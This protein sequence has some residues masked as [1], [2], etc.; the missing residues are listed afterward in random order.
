MDRAYSAPAGD[1]ALPGDPLTFWSVFFQLAAGVVLLFRRSEPRRSVRILAVMLLLN[2]CVTAMW[3]WAFWPPRED[4]RR[5]AAAFDAPTEILVFAF[6]ASLG[7][8][9]RARRMTNVL[10]VAAAAVGLIAPFMY[11]F[12]TR[13]YGVAFEQFR[14]VV[15]FVG[16]G[17]VTLRLSRGTESWENWAALG[18]LARAFYWTTVSGAGAV[19]VLEGI[20]LPK[21]AY[22]IALA[23]ILLVFCAVALGRLLRA[24]TPASHTVVVLVSLS[25]VAIGV[26]ELLV[27]ATEPVDTT[28]VPML[29][30]LTLTVH[31]PFFL[32]VGL[33]PGMLRSVT[34]RSLAAAVVGWAGSMGL[35]SFYPDASGAAVL[36][37]FMSGALALAL[38]EALWPRLETWDAP[39]SAAST[40]S[41]GPRPSD[42][43]TPTGSGVFSSGM[44]GQPRVHA[45]VQPA[46]DAGLTASIVPSIQAAAERFAA[47]ALSALAA[48]PAVTREEPA[49]APPAVRAVSNDLAEEADASGSEEGLGESDASVTGRPQ[50]QTVL[51]SLRGS[52][53]PAGEPPH[54]EIML[55]Q[56]SLVS[57]TGVRAPRISTVVRE[58]NASAEQRLDQYAPGWRLA[59]PRVAQPQLV[60]Q[61]RGNAPGSP[62]VWVYYRLTP[63]GELLAERITENAEV[64]TNSASD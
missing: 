56:K 61:F 60:Q 49:R 15:Y 54:G 12:P 55:T 58:L 50:W 8:S 45:P 36:A 14:T 31:R 53:L 1:K 33:A 42:G 39:A 64:S 22:L 57:R 44:P 23:P 2:A 5:I 63:L 27:R 24:S 4:G 35:A 19:R 18:F 20:A 48:T 7:T 47:P 59:H 38:I 41:S 40:P 37:G 6:L 29:S 3:F 16:L 21:D 25:G 62:G 34:A 46:H 52:A 9:T 13:W 26:T 43:P 51:S 30:L 32:L 17:L 10:L 11:P 28:L